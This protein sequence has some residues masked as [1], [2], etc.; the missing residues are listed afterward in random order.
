MFRDAARS[1]GIN[2]TAFKM[3]AMAISAS[4]D[5]GTFSRRI[6]IS[7]ARLGK[8]TSGQPIFAVDDAIAREI[9]ATFILGAAFAEG[10]GIL[11][12]VVGAGETEHLCHH[13]AVG[14][15]AAVFAVLEQARYVQLTHVLGD[16]GRNL[17]LE[18][19]E[20]RGFTQTLVDFRWRHF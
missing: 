13:L 10:L 20:S 15:I 1:L 8:T 19:N 2:I 16:L 18:V 17:T 3:L 14:I 6:L 11:A 12:F 9:R 5:S 4:P 7:S